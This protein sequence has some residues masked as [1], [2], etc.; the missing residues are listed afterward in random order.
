VFT[1]WDATKANEASFAKD[2]LAETKQYNP[3]DKPLF[4]FG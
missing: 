1:P 3:I 2:Q 4:F